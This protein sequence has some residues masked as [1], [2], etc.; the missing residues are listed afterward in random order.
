MQ[1]DYMDDIVV[2]LYY[3]PDRSKALPSEELY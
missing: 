1:V 3:Y 2:R